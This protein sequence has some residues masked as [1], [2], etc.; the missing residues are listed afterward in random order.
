MIANSPL[1][2]IHVP[3][4]WLR[5]LHLGSPLVDVNWGGPVYFY[6]GAS[7]LFCEVASLVAG[8]AQFPDKILSSFWC[9]SRREAICPRRR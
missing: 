1:L 9:G 8:K 2:T 7:F 6:G 5:L 4:R 3:R